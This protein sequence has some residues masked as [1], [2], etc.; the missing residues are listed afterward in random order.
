MKQ[1]S[2]KKLWHLLID[3]NLKK[4]DLLDATGMSSSTLAKMAAGE[5]VTVEILLRVCTA[6]DCDFADIMETIPEGVKP[7]KKCKK[8]PELERQV[9][10]ISVS[11]DS[12]EVNCQETKK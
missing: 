6:L 7:P 8:L 4:N 9:H 1:V 12:M 3:R 11:R 10:K 5:P 2:Y